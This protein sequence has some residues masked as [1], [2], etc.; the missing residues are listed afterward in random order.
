MLSRTTRPVWDIQPEASFLKTAAEK[1][2]ER[3]E[4]R[5]TIRVPMTTLLRPEN[6]S[7]GG[8]LLTATNRLPRIVWEYLRS[9]LAPLWMSLHGQR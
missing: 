6:I 5:A 9:D 2:G 8:F 1:S 4:R 7:G 3:T